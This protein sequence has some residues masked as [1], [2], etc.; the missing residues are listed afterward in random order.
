[1]SGPDANEEPDGLDAALVR[2][3]LSRMLPQQSAVAGA[4][5]TIP[6]AL[7]E[8]EAAAVRS[9]A[10]TSGRAEGTV[11]LEIESMLRLTVRGELL[12]GRLQFEQAS[13]AHLC[14]AEILSVAEL[15]ARLHLPL[16]VIRVVASDLIVAGMVE[17]F[18]P[19]LNIA[20][21]IDLISRLIEGVRAL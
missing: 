16:G 12:S 9:Y 10:I 6:D 17:A 4:G 8:V 13:I 1:V 11:P 5:S 20:D 15:S 18:L 3:F 2:P 7:A 21:D 19:S 14:G